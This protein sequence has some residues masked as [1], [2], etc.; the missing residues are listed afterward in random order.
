MK[1]WDP[2]G[3]GTAAPDATMNLGYTGHEAADSLGL[4]LGGVPKVSTVKHTQF[5]RM[6][7]SSWKS[8]HSVWRFCEI[9]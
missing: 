6:Q 2:E 4:R 8:Y 9:A 5:G 3:M 7:D 1:A